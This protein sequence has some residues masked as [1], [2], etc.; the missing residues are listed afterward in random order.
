MCEHTFAH[1]S[2]V[3]RAYRVTL[4]D[5]TELVA[6]GDHR[7]LSR[8]GWKHVTGSE[9]GRDHRPHLTLNDRLVSTGKFATRPAEDTDYRRGYL[10]GTD[11]GDAHLASREYQ[12]PGGSS[13][14]HHTFRLVP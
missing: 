2:T 5:G 9:W 11:R 7:F 12:R 10:C 1:W 4:E 14:T 8:G 13:W 6:S 3:K